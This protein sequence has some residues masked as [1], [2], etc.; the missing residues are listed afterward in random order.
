MFRSPIAPN[1]MPAKKGVLQ[2]IYLQTDDRQT[3]VQKKLSVFLNNIDKTYSHMKVHVNIPYCK[4]DVLEM[5]REDL[6]I[7]SLR[8]KNCKPHV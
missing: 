5:D 4:R 2:Y 3:E 1:K 7:S 8:Q 6:S